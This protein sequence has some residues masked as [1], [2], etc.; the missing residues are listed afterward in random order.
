MKFIRRTK[1]YRFLLENEFSFLLFTLALLLIIP[2]FF[3]DET[4]QHLV[5]HILLSIVL[6][7][8]V[9]SVIDDRKL[10]QWGGIIAGISFG[11]HWIDYFIPPSDFL[12]IARISFF[13][14][15]FSVITYHT[16]RLIY[17]RRIVTLDTLYGAFNGFILIGL[18]GGFLAMLIE[19]IFPNSYEIPINTNTYLD[20]ELIYFAFVTQTTLG[21][22]DVVPLTTPAQTLSI[23]LSITGQIYMTFLVAMLV[24]KYIRTNQ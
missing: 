12:A 14:I 11:L 16:I 3:F 24:G 19:T 15:F 20:F 1:L 23:I 17:N 18:I 5:I 6:V 22:G 21:Y 7:A 4:R 13:L 8:G 10:R 2:S 9:N